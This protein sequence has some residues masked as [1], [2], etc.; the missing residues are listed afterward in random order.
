MPKL[1]IIVPNY[2]HSK[3]LAKRI[4][5]ILAQTYQN[6]E[7]I[8]LDDCSTDDSLCVLDKYKYNPKVTHFI[9]NEI[10][11]GSVF[12]QWN[13]GIEL[14]KGELIW[15]AESDDIASIDFLEKMI[16]V[17]DKHDKTVLAYCQSNK[18]NSFGDI[19]GDWLDHTEIN[20]QN[21]H[22][23]DFKMNGN[24]FIKK[25]MID[26]NSI[27]NASGVIFRKSVYQSVGGPLTGL[28]TVGDWNVWVKILA[29]GEIYF[30]AEKL[31]FFRMHDSSC[32]AMSSKNDKRACIIL[33]YLNMYE[34][35]SNYLC[36]ID[37]KL[38][39][40]MRNKRNIAASKFLLNCISSKNYQLLFDNFVKL[41]LYFIF[42]NLY[43]YIVSLRI[44]A[45]LFLNNHPSK[46]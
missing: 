42:F 27:P 33:M 36:E 10:N 38:S 15:I 5:S 8:I 21:K 22:T 9:L 12:K 40:K 46:I 31:N 1:S 41:K 17:F 24:E 23:Y 4:D 45:N 29:H 13:K 32:V 6:F 43:F 11:S 18:I 16:H 30:C 19:Y 37:L 28:R 26:Q 3:Y 44:M 25:Y 35:L 14:A 34:D 20:G 39:K 2:N 7:V